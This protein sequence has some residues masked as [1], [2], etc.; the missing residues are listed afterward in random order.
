M[1]DRPKTDP[2]WRPADALIGRFIFFELKISLRPT[3][4]VSGRFGGI[5]REVKYDRAG[6]LRLTRVQRAGGDKVNDENATLSARYRGD[7]EWVYPEEI[8]D[9]IV[10]R[11]SAPKTLA[12]FIA[13]AKETVVDTDGDVE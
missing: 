2:K 9:V 7:L 6:N 11:N 1:Q 3:N 8:R 4:P 13:A 12:D 10:R 5:V